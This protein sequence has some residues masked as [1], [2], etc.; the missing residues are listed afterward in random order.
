MVRSSSR[1]LA[2]SFALHAATLASGADPFWGLSRPT[3]K[4]LEPTVGIGVDRIVQVGNYRIGC[5]DRQGNELW[6]AR[7]NND[8]ADEDPGFSPNYFWEGVDGGQGDGGVDA[9]MLYDQFVLSSPGSV[10]RYAGPVGEG[11]HEASNRS[12]SDAVAV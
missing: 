7:L 8:P 10:A 2:L 1:W 3:N 5:Y 6:R 12:P 4:R 11:Y 9:S